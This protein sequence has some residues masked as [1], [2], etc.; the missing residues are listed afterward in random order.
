MPTASISGPA[1]GIDG[2]GGLAFDRNDNLTVASSLNNSLLTFARGSN[3]NV[4]PIA[5]LAGSATGLDVPFGIDL[6]L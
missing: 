3:G 5:T 1:T 4:A 6:S 2:P